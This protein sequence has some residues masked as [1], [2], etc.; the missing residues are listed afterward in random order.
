M[1]S[2][3]RDR[4]GKAGAR[5]AGPGCDGEFDIAQLAER[6]G[7]LNVDVLQ[8]VL[9][10]IVKSEL[11]PRLLLGDKVLLGL[12][13][14][15]DST[16]RHNGK[17]NEE[18]S[19]ADVQ[20]FQ[21][22][23][24]HRDTYDCV[25][26]INRLRERGVSLSDLYLGLFTPVARELGRGWE[27]DELSFIDVTK[28]VGRLQS[29]VHAFSE[30]HDR[31]HPIDAVRRIALASAPEDQHVLGMLIAS[32]MFEQEG[33]DVVG[34][35]GLTSGRPLNALVQDQWLAVVGLTASCEEKALLLKRAIVELREA[36]RN[37]AV[38]VVVGGQGFVD[39]P[40]ISIQIGADDLVT[41]A[42]DAVRQA[43]RLLSQQP[44]DRGH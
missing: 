38:C 20:A 9:S 26:F 33:W 14:D 32:K 11:V 39:H 30:T 43:E 24:L 40:E 4:T 16:A 8:S 12:A 7:Q 36:S 23:V 35:P 41:D 18:P 25:E 13:Q 42:K 17:A 21:V 44:R 2:E 15:T 34:G 10:G 3:G 19:G 29:F 6:P 28:A 5:S 31:P 37:E 1:P 27:N 22:L